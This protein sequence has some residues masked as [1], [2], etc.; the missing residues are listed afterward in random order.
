M[1]RRKAKPGPDQASLLEARVTTA[2]CVPAIRKAV[3]EWR[4][5]KYKGATETS[6]LLLNYWFSTDHRM[7]GGEPFA[8]YYAQREAVETLVF[9][10]EVEGHPA[11]S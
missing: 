11:P 6:K 2:P 8:Y 9:L 5:R 3:T 1:P 7:P 10:F 4:D